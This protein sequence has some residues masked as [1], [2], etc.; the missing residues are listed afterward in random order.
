M[1][2]HV[3]LFPEVT[4][5]TLWKKHGSGV[6]TTC[7]VFRNEIYRVILFVGPCHP[8]SHD[9]SRVPV[10]QV[11]KPKELQPTQELE[12]APFPSQPVAQ[13]SSVRGRVETKCIQVLD[14]R[15][16]CFLGLPECPQI[17]LES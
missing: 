1:T 7:L 16:V 13:P 10:V 11:Q 4:S 12:K 2:G 17:S 6:N 9:D 3:H 15:D 8:R 5:Y 14:A